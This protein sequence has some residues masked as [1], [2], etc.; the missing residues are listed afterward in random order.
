MYRINLHRAFLCS[1]AATVSQG[2]ACQVGAMAVGESGAT[3]SNVVGVPTSDAA[4]SSPVVAATV[5]DVV[6][7]PSVDAGA[8]VEMPKLKKINILGFQLEA[9]EKRAR[10]SKLLLASLCF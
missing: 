1:F 8:P 6:T 7:T 9:E 3:L 5:A 2:D 10:N 4:V